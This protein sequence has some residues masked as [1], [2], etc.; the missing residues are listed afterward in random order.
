MVDVETESFI[1]MKLNF[2]KIPPVLKLLRLRVSSYSNCLDPVYFLFFGER[3]YYFWFKMFSG[4]YVALECFGDSRMLV[5]KLCLPGCCICFGSYIKLFVNMYILSFSLKTLVTEPAVPGSVP[6]FLC[7][8]SVLVKW[9]WTLHSSH[10]C[11]LK[12]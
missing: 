11:L 5:S 7:T 1:Y 4:L 3:S 10:V 2:K 9:L 6:C 12:Q 8:V